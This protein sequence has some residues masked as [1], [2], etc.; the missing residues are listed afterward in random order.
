MQNAYESNRAAQRIVI[1]G[2]PSTGK[3]SIINELVSRGFRCL[4]EI[5]RQV[6]LEA[7]QQGIE[8]LFL[9]DP[10]LFS[11]K[12]LDGRISQFHEALAFNDERVFL[13]RGIPDIVAYMDYIGDAYPAHFVAACENHIYDKVFILRPW[14]AIYQ[15]DSER[16]ENYGQALKIHD[17]LLDAYQR[18]GYELL[19][20]PFESVEKRAAFIVNSIE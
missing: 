10:L 17:H 2:G 4:E 5:S 7:R 13:D 19:D 9:T 14:E 12:L 16:Y 1:T 18:Y 8:Q 15:S 11:Q 20:V 3:T 6:I